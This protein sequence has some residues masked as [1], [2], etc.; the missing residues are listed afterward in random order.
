MPEYGSYCLVETK[1]GRLW[2][3]TWYP[4]DYKDKK[5]TAG[6]FSRGTADSFDVSE[7]SK[8]LALYRYDLT[9][10]LEEEDINHQQQRQ[11]ADDQVAHGAAASA[12]L[13]GSPGLRLGLLA[14]LFGLGLG[15][16]FGHSRRR[17]RRCLRPNLLH[18]GFRHLCIPSCFFHVFGAAG[19]FCQAMVLL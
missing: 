15:F 16:G 13:L 14:G 1:D 17:L 5:S 2:A 12:A 6:K 7:V 9:N 11:G 18:V 8:W 4:D 3:G 19:F 10:C